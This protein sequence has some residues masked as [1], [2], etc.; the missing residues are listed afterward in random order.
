MRKR[1][2]CG[3]VV[4]C[5]LVVVF[6]CVFVVSFVGNTQMV[7]S[8]NDNIVVYKG[9]SQS[10]VS[11]MFNVYWGT[12]YLCQILEILDKYQATCTFFVGGTWVA[13]HPEMLKLI[14]DSG[15]EIANHGYFHKQ[16]SILNYE[17]NIQEIDAC[18]KLVWEYVGVK[19]S[20]FAPPSGDFDNKTVDACKTL[21]YKLIM[22]SKDTI[23]WRDKDDQVILSRATKNISA[24]DL[25][26]MHPT[27]YTL[28]ALEQILQHYKSVGLS[29]ITV[30]ENIGELCNTSNNTKVDLD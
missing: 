14:V 29:V 4:N 18:S 9:N 13:Q 20:L 2:F 21:G 11:L 23:D 22:W 27:K 15:H 10:A 17:Q 30:S 12:E 7:Y 6:I 28:L 25:V 3:G 26:L 24:G 8:N 5:C 1:I 16:H 19:P